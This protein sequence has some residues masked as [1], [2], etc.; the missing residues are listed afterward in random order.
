MA[1]I[2]SSVGRGDHE[3]F[4]R[5]NAMQFRRKA[6]GVVEGPL[7]EGSLNLLGDCELAASVAGGPFKFTVT[8]PYM[9]ARTLLDAHYQDLG[10]LTLAIADAL[11]AQ[12]GELNCACVQV[13]EA[14]VPGN[15]ADG[16]LAAKAINRLLDAA[17]VE[18]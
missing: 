8:S 1:G 12:I 17:H 5:K 11:A 14:N 4:A 15:P 18:K 6:A 2:R 10:K 3:A 16:P 7:G 13:D 9:L